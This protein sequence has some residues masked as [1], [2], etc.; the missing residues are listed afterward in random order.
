MPCIEQPLLLQQQQ[1]PNNGI[2]GEHN[3]IKSTLH[4][5][6]ARQQ[7]ASEELA[8]LDWQPAAA[9]EADAGDQDRLATLQSEFENCTRALRLEQS[10]VA[11][12]EAALEAAQTRRP[13]V[14]QDNHAEET[15]MDHLTHV[16]AYI[17]AYPQRK[18]V[19]LNMM[20]H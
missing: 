2:S 13:A 15:L 11:E 3:D 12:L 20:S 10:R 5:E 14:H 17:K 16:W 19:L 7:P 18:Q 6:E 4:R 8:D 9:T 1:P